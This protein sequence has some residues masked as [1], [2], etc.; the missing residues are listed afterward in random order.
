MII[1][2]EIE[3]RITV[4]KAVDAEVITGANIKIENGLKIPPVKN[5]KKPS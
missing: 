1:I 4:S 5:S 2:I 3:E